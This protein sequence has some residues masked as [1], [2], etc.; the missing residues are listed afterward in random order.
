MWL[1]V[2]AAD[3]W[4]RHVTLLGRVAAIEPDPELEGSTACRVITPAGRIQTE[5]V[6]G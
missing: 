1:T 2:L 6:R 4:Y 3:D 5:S